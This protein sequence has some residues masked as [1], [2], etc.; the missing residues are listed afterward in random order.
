M[1]SV[2]LVCEDSTTCA[3]LVKALHNILYLVLF[4]A[5]FVHW[6]R[7]FHFMSLT[8]GCIQHKTRTLRRTCRAVLHVLHCQEAPFFPVIDLLRRCTWHMSFWARACT[9]V[10]IDIPE[11]DRHVHTHVHCEDK[12]L[13]QSL[14][15]MHSATSYVNTSKSPPLY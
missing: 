11:R 12:S 4:L 13:I 9:W 15:L 5:S 3:W 1:K 10:Q 6:L 2:Y 8:V 7:C 14:T